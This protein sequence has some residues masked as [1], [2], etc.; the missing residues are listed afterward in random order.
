MSKPY[1]PL[2]TLVAKRN[3]YF[4]AWR[5]VLPH[6]Q[7]Q[8]SLSYPWKLPFCA[9]RQHGIGFVQLEVCCLACTPLRGLHTKIIVGPSFSHKKVTAS[10]IELERRTITLSCPWGHLDKYVLNEEPEGFETIVELELLA[11]G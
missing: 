8:W 9:P 11:G 5:S 4:R 1:V 7:A 6:L 3:A 10:M 2:A